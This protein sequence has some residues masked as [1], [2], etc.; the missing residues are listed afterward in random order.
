MK[1]YD[2]IKAKKIINENTSDILEASLGMQE[3]WFFTAIVVY[4]SNIWTKELPD[5]ADKIFNEY[6]KSK[7]HTEID[8]L[9]YDNILIA[10]IYYSAWA[11]SVLQLVYNDG[12]EKNNSML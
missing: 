3:D 5:N 7:N 10:G 12:I 4:E 6:I 1:T 8:K 2:F 11:T 9:I